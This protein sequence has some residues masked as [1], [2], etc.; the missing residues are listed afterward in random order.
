MNVLNVI[1]IAKVRS[2]RKK[3]EKKEKKTENKELETKN[4]Q[5]PVAKHGER[6]VCMLSNT[7]L[8]REA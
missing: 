5:H 8:T 7:A 2:K 4:W 3:R 1:K 6:L